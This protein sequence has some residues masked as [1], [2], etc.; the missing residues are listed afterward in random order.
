VIQTHSS[1]LDG[2]FGRVPPNYHFQ[3]YPGQI[4]QK[5]QKYRE[6][7][8]KTLNL[9]LANKKNLYDRTIIN[10]VCFA[11][12]INAISLFSSDSL[13]LCI[14]L[15]EKIPRTDLILEV[16]ET[17]QIIKVYKLEIAVGFA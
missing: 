4:K 6:N 1:Y 2:G 16:I 5:L 17:Q 7:L 13:K 3:S 10:I 14:N 15:L 11:L 9:T 12:K 8:L